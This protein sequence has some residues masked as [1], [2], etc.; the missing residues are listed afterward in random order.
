MVMCE[1]TIY[2]RTAYVFYFVLVLVLCIPHDMWALLC[3]SLCFI[4]LVS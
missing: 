4:F 2:I 1:G 3:V